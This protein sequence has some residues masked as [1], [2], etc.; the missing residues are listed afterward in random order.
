VGNI[1]TSNTSIC[2]GCGC[3]LDV[4]Q[5]VRGLCGNLECD[6]KDVPYQESR[7]R[8]WLLKSIRQ[9]IPDTWSST[10]PI[11]L[12]PRNE[13]LLVPLPDTRYE[14]HRGYLFKIVKEARTCYE[15][16][17]ELLAESN[18]PVNGIS[19]IDATLPVLSTAC[20]LCRGECCYTGGNSA[21]LRPATI[22]RQHWFRFGVSDKRIVDFY[23]SYLPVTS[24][25]DS[26]VYQGEYGCTLPRNLRANKCNQ[27]L[28]KELGDLVSALAENEGSSCIAA[29][30]NNNSAECI[31]TVDAL[32]VLEI[33]IP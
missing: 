30:I 20:G 11:V 15:N 3:K 31:A 1:V 4:L 13:R 5:R 12:L 2:R 24:F 23:L 10:L 6:R 21:W 29:A 16:D 28:C 27:F 33:A 17:G 18:A 22:Q 26:C 19:S 32:G 14:T 25:E 7:R 9:Q 8:E